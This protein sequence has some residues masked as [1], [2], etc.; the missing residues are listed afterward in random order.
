MYCIHCGAH[1]AHNYCANC[2]AA[3]TA[4][5]TRE[6]A[7]A[8][9]WN[10]IDQTSDIIVAEIVW[11]DTLQYDVILRQPE[12]RTRIAAYASETTPGITGDDLLAVFDAVSNVGFSLKKLSTA[13]LPIYDKLGI[14]TSRKTQVKFTAPPGRVLLA[15]LCALAA[16]GFKIEEV[17]Q[18]P[19][20]CCLFAK[21][22]MGFIT[23]SG[24]LRIMLN[25]REGA[26]EAEV[27]VSISGQWYDWGKSQALIDALC[28]KISQDLFDQQTGKSAGVAK[29]A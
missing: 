4:D 27:S 9:Q 16:K 7:L 26:V 23:N 22:P 11:T 14:K 2:G 12:A 25:E 10:S 29:V 1:G 20:A 24:H 17:E 8:S 3:Q 19:Q 6:Q 28:T 21:I 18:A 5:N 15:A 13:I